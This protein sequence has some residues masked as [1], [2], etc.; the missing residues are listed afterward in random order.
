MRLTAL[1]LAGGA[2]LLGTETATVVVEIG[3]PGARL[4]ADFLGLS[5]E[6]NALVESHFTPAN[7]V[8]INL[9]RNLGAGSLRL[10]GNKVE[11]TRWQAEA[12]ASLDK[13]TGLAVIGRSTLDDLYGFLRATEWNCLHGLNLAGN[14]PEASADEA[15]YALKVGA[16]S[17]Q[18]FEVGNE[19][20]LYPNHALRPKGYD[21]PQGHPR[22]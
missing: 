19:P 5:Y 22:P 10:G 14:R 8:L 20:N 6:K 15:A 12:P 4:P 18:A 16:A 7:T 2:A 17:V 9:H 21:C 1:L 13:S 3:R 11:L